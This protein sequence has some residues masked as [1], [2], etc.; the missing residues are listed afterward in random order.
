MHDLVKQLGP[1]EAYTKTVIKA[2][3]AVTVLVVLGAVFIVYV[4][5][6]GGVVPEQPDADPLEDTVPPHPDDLPPL[7]PSCVWPATCYV[8]QAYAG[9]PGGESEPRG[10]AEQPFIKF[11]QGME[12][13]E[14]WGLRR[15]AEGKVIVNPGHYAAIGEYDYPT[16]IEAPAGEVYLEGFPEL[17]GDTSCTSD[18]PDCNQ[19]VRGS[20]VEAFNRLRSHGDILAFHLGDYPEPEWD[21]WWQF[22]RHWQGVQRIPTGGGQ[23]M[24]ATRDDIDGWAWIQPGWAGFAVVKM[25]SRNDDGLR[26]R[27]NRL[28]PAL[29][30]EWTA[31]PYEDRIQTMKPVSYEDKHIGGPQAMGDILI[32]DSEHAIYL[33]D[34]SD[35]EHPRRIGPYDPGRIDDSGP[36]LVRPEYGVSAV[37]IAKLRDG[38]FLIVVTGGGAKALDFYVSEEADILSAYSNFDR[39]ERYEVTGD[40]GLRYHWDNYQSANLVTECDTGDLYLVAAANLDETS[41]V[42][43]PDVPCYPDGEDW[44]SLYR[45]DMKDPNNVALHK[46]AEFHAYCT[47]E[48]WGQPAMCEVDPAYCLRGPRQC[49]FDAAA[50]AYVDHRGQLIIYA[51]EHDNQAPS[52]ESAGSIRMMEFRPV[53]HGPCEAIEDAWIELFEHEHFA[54]QGRMIDY[55]DRNLENYAEYHQVGLEYFGDQ[56]S[57]A[58]WCIP[59]GWGY[60][61]YEHSNYEGETLLIVGIGE[62]RQLPDLADFDFGDRI[63]SSAWVNLSNQTELIEG[64]VTIVE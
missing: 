42:C 64:E 35:P 33:Y 36:I 4:Y 8:D 5:A 21:N 10:V 12:L 37:A 60:R 55:R 44:A 32:T 51:T 16:T 11:T 46:V 13:A 25:A 3:I 34:M 49:N 54:G 52:H 18:S 28:M 20:I 58:R 6:Q 48:P 14:A 26:Y 27:S 59:D 43:P 56:A 57:S 62:Y 29:P 30:F 63:S 9:E 41:N 22:H 1:S 45:I 40:A 50:G 23:Y 47:F 24:V 61:L 15:Q 39:W 2:G 38:R 53:P 17:K 19:C 31:P 7:P